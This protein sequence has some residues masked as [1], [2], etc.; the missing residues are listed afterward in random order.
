M[1]VP[2][3]SYEPSD[4]SRITM[5][6]AAHQVAHSQHKSILHPT[7]FVCYLT[8]STGQQIHTPLRYNLLLYKQL[9]PRVGPTKHLK[10]QVC[11]SLLINSQIRTS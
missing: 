9:N 1:Q 2:L 10:H 5:H 6:G 4:N 11:Y 8:L 3:L 7:Q